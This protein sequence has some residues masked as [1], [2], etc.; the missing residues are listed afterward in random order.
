MSLKATLCTFALQQPST[1]MPPTLKRA[2]VFRSPC[3]VFVVLLAKSAHTRFSS[4]VRHMLMYIVVAC[5]PALLDSSLCFHSHA[6]EVRLQSSEA[7]RLR[8]KIWWRKRRQ[9]LKNRT[10]NKKFGILLSDNLVHI[11]NE[12]KSGSEDV[13]TWLTVSSVKWY[14]AVLHIIVRLWRVTSN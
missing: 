14:L 12:F 13:K 2:H 11:R 5:A 1:H 10:K 8:S 4:L 6:H 3:C 9:L 7:N